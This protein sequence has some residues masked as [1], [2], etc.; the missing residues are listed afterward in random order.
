MR[1]ETAGELEKL[2]KALSMLITASRQVSKKEI[3]NRS[4][5]VSHPLSRVNDEAAGRAIYLSRPVQGRAE[6]LG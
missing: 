6:A 1:Y 3:M 4:V 2:K 5:N